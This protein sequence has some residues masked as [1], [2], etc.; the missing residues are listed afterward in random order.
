MI[1][2][3][4]SLFYLEPSVDVLDE[5]E[6]IYRE[7][8][9]YIRAVIYWLVREDSIDDIVQET[10]IKAWKSYG[11]FN[12]DSSIKTWLYRIA[13]NCAIDHLRKVKKDIEYDYR[14]ESY[15][16]QA[17]TRDIISKG[18]FKLSIEQREVFILH[19]K[20]GNTSREIAEIL[21]LKEGTVK[22]RLSSSREIIKKFLTENGV[23]YER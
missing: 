11:K 2:K 1:K 7:H 3:L 17:E 14:I 19:Y 5:F 18:L 16:S 23:Q 6:S 10:F 21:S 20:F 8:R 15:E 12:H 4:T 13:R 22:S 9:D